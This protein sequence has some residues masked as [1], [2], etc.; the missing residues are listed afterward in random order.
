MLKFFQKRDVMVRIFLGFVMGV[1]GL[2]MVV[3]LAPGPVGSL[4]ESTTA[5]AEVGGQRV[6]LADVQRQL[7]RIERVQPIPG[8]LRTLYT[9]QV[10]DQLMFARMLEVESKRLGI[11][12][13]DEERAERI[14]QI[15]PTAFAGDTFVG[16]E[17]YSQEVEQRFNMSVA[18]FEELIRQSLLEEKFRDLVTDGIRV[19]PVEV[20]QEFRRRNEKVVLEYAVLKPEELQAQVPTPESEVSAFFESNKARYQVPERRSA[21]YILLDVDQLR[22]SADVTDAELR[23]YYDDH[24]DRYRVQ[25]RVHVR[26][27]L[28][29][30][31]GKTDAE[32][33]EIRAKAEDVLKQARRPGAKFEDLARKYSED[34]TKDSGGDLGWIVQGQTVP[35]FE[36]TA[37]SLPKGAISD[38]V[39]TQY[40]FHIIQVLDRQTARTK[41]LEEVRGEI[42]PVLAAEKAERLANQRS[43][44]LAAEVR[45]SNRRPLEEVARKFN[46]PVRET[47][48]LAAGDNPLELGSASEFVDQLFRLRE[49]ELGGPVRID[50]GYVV[51]AVREIQPAHQGT[52]AEVR[53]R[54]LDD[55]RREKA[56][57][58]ARSRAEELARRTQSGA[59]LAQAAKALGVEVKTSDPLARTG[60]LPDVGP[61]RQ[62]ADAFTMPVGK[63]SPGV[64]LG[65]RW[66]VYRVVSREEPKPEELV[67]QRVEIESQVLQTKRQ[68]AYDAFRTELENRLRLEGELRIN[69][70]NF[71]RLT[72]SS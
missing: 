58:L 56:A 36:Q 20:E 28:F 13:T 8:P 43:D 29:K 4:A 27:I 60:S 50:R 59:S 17:R 63:T 26:H 55:F 15:I 69:E 16:M 24:I 68:V 61:A 66:L 23:T 64:F 22:Q 48:L 11:R 65:A 72:S 14:K 1:I 46:L 33:E 67:K 25:N 44:Q 5:V 49:G 12:V 19:T 10:L 21:R 31:I 3:T 70:E 62:V 54:V 51:L 7:A 30:T 57:D 6:T 18:E 32:V 40:G 39:K 47:R 71:K 2:M 35:E 37:F 34:T 41:S 9:R 38:L 45:Q 42:L 52:L 53:D